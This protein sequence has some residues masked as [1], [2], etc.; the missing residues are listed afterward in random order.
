[1]KLHVPTAYNFINSFVF[2]SRGFLVHHFLRLA[3][4]SITEN[5]RNITF[6]FLCTA[7]R[8]EVCDGFDFIKIVT[9]Q[10]DKGAQ[11]K[12]ANEKMATAKCMKSENLLI[13]LG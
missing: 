8:E 4:K 2:C 7:Q 1:M 5:R 12:E 6:S 10:L 9:M 11:D 3:V 13:L